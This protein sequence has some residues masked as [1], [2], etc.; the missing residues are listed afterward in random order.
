MKDKQGV[1]GEQENETVSVGK[2]GGA[3]REE[4]PLFSKYRLLLYVEL[5]LIRNKDYGDI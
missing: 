1:S 2:K 5:R 3:K 4:K